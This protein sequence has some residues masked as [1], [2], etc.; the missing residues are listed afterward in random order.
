M[1]KNH[2]PWKTV[3]NFYHD[4]FNK[5]PQAATAAFKWKPFVDNEAYDG[6]WKWCAKHGVKIVLM[7][8]N[9]LDVLI[10]RTK[11]AENPKLDPHCHA[12]HCLKQHKHV[13]VKL[14]LGDL[15]ERLDEFTKDDDYG[16]RKCHEYDLDYI[17]VT[18][19]DMFSKD[20]ERQLKAWH[21]V[22][23]F[24]RGDIFAG[25]VNEDKVKIVTGFSEDTSPG[26]REQYVSN[27]KEVQEAVAV[28][29][30][31]WTL[32]CSTNDH[33]GCTKAPTY[34]EIFSNGDFS[35]SADTFHQQANDHI[36]IS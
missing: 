30:Y 16:R 7:T 26:T 35:L 3:E 24:L 34:K 12:H 36:I 31:A 32:K 10:S 6:L 18:Y 21:A 15:I 22:V 13:T 19:E 9:P 33:Q 29:K 28:S 4:A 27:W 14:K 1:R 17:E 11:H 2:K 25:F 5:Y 20:R 23:R 8:R